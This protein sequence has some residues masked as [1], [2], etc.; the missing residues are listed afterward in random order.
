MMAPLNLPGSFR[1]PGA[2]RVCRCVSR[3]LRVRSA[4]KLL[5]VALLWLASSSGRSWLPPSV[6]PSS[7]LGAQDA[8]PGAGGAPPAEGDAP[9]QPEK[10]PKFKKPSAKDSFTKGR[11]LY[12]E[13][14][15]KEAEASFKKAKGDASGPED[16]ALVEGW[17]Q[18]AAGGQILERLK[19]RVKNRQLRLAYQEGENYAARFQSTPIGPQFRAF[20]E[21]LG[22]QLFVMI[23]DFNNPSPEYSEKYGKTFVQDEKLLAD[24]T[25]CL[26]WV[27]TKEKGPAA[28]KVRDVPRD[29]RGLDAIELWVNVIKVPPSPEAVLLCSSAPP[30]GKKAARAPKK[31]KSA[32]G[33]GVVDSYV[34]GMRV[35]STRGKWQKIRLPLAEFKAQG[36]ASLTTV[37]GFQIQVSGGQEFE[38]L[39]DR[40]VAVRKDPGTEAK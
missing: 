36:S 33:G 34:L 5:L 32:A 35:T 6:V 1:V 17:L 12:D 25:P 31:K 26:R 13:G 10:E 39:V 11:S 20:L 27:N 19:A 3:C 22:S 7:F 9:A 30:G 18:A 23:E 38:L 8:P 16:R 37:S 4:G 15:F 28:L 24:G 2:P 21:E 14:K 40:I 29:W